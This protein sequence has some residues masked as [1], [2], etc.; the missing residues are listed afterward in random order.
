M[1]RFKF[2]LQTSLDLAIRYEQMAREDMLIRIKE[3]DTLAAELDRLERK[4]A[5]LENDLRL[6]M[7][8][9]QPL[10]KILLMRD[11]LPVLKEQREEASGALQMAV[12]AVEKA[13]QLLVER[14]KETKTLDRLREK[15]WL[16]YCQE[17][18]KEEQKQID[19]VATSRFIRKDADRQ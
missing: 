5:E 14:M 4:L 7:S 16:A 6:S 19:E 13:R 8:N 10:E 15:E 9:S 17:Q 18:L 2:R 3:R 11:F 12:Q 1:P